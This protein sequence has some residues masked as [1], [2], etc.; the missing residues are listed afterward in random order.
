MACLARMRCLISVSGVHAMALGIYLVF[1]KCRIGFPSI[2]GAISRT[3]LGSQ[4]EG[5]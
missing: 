4:K 2:V 5:I 1:P 3:P